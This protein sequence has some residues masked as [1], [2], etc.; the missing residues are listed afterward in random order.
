MIH[1][2]AGENVCIQAITPTQASSALASSIARRMAAAS[3]STGFATT[4]ARDVGGG[5]QR[6]GDLARLVGDLAQHVLAVQA[7]AAGE[8]PDLAV[9]VR[10][11]SSAGSWR[12]SAGWP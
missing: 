11:G 2:F 3:V 1:I 8:E 7:L 5:V 4:T 6:V 12:S 10:G 9:L